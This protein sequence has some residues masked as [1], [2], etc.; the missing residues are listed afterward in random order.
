MVI[1]KC[2][3]VSQ[4]RHGRKMGKKGEGG[5]CWLKWAVFQLSNPLAYLFFPLTTGR[6]CYQACSV[7]RDFTGG[8]RTAKKRS[9]K[10]VHPSFASKLSHCA[11]KTHHSSFMWM[12]CRSFYFAFR[13][14]TWQSGSTIWQR[15]R[16]P[17]P[18]FR[19]IWR[20]WSLPFSSLWNTWRRLYFNKH[21]VRLFTHFRLNG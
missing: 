14:F 4:S 9:V 7:E 6:Y 21:S 15:R 3:V 19:W 17:M 8:G 2:E 18:I 20:W 11:N 5:D 1:C 10:W 16:V 13:T 12:Q